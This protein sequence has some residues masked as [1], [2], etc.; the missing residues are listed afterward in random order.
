M[1]MNVGRDKAMQQGKA[2]CSMY[3]MLLILGLPLEILLQL[4]VGE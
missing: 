3:C 4:P 2:N 1:R